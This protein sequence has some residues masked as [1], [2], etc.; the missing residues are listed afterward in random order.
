MNKHLLTSMCIMACGLQ[1][2]NAQQI[3]IAG[4]ITDQSGAPISGVT[5]SIKGTNVAV[6][7]NAN[8]LFAL[9]ADQNATLVISY[10]GYVPQEV[11]VSGRKTINVSLTSTDQE[12]DE[13]IVV[14]YG[15]A[16]KSS[17]TGSASSVTSDDIK[18][19]P[20]TSFE[21]AICIRNN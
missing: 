21:P 10:V 3:P 2:V 20:T 4:K 12:L 15:T 13:V 8:G 5:I 1:V 17:Y 11:N 16:K 9:N 14:A 6:S 19:V 7:T 18:D